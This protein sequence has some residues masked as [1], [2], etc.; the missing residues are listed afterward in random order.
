MRFVVAATE[1]GTDLGVV[2]DASSA[3]LIAAGLL[4]VII[5]PATG[6]SL[7]RRD[8]DGEPSTK[9]DAMPTP[10]MPVMPAEMR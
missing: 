5:F 7:L 3:A 9:E 8:K 1:I 6:L 4:S 10:A 2:S